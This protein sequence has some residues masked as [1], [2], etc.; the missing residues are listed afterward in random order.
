[1][2]T[3]VAILLGLQGVVFITWAFFLFKNLFRL[4]RD[5]KEQLGKE[6][7]YNPTVMETLTAFGWFLK[8]PRYQ[9]ARMI[10]LA[11]TV[12]MFAVIGLNAMLIRPGE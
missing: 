3:G 5:V 8:E 10:L 4:R 2:G 6:G 9:R 12:V 11:L 7:F 1:M